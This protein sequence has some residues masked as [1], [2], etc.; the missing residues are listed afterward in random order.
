MFLAKVFVTPQP[1]DSDP[2]ERT[3][4]GGLGQLGFHAARSVRAGKYLEVRLD[5]ESAEDAARLVRD[6]CDRLLANP[7]IEDYRFEMEELSGE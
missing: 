2:R 5:V 6:M 3:T 7:V 4:R 1:T